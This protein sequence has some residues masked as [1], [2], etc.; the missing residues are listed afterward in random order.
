MVS[1]SSRSGFRSA[2]LAVVTGSFWFCSLLP[3]R[4][5]Q[6]P[7]LTGALP[8]IAVQSNAGA[9]A[10]N[11][12][13]FF[14]AQDAPGTVVRMVFASDAITGGTGSI[15]IALSDSATPGTVANF[16]NYVRGGA[17]V[18]SFLHRSGS[19]EGL[20]IIQGGG[21][22]IAN[23]T[24]DLSASTLTAVSTGS[25]IVNES[26]TSRPNARGT[27][28]MARTSDPN[29]ATSQWFINTSDNTTNLGGSD[30]AGYTVFGTV[31][32]AGMDVADQVFA[33]PT[34]DVHGRI[35]NN[36][37]GA[38]TELPTNPQFTGTGSLTIPR[39]DLVVVNSAGVIPALTFSAQSDTPS[40]A[41]I[42]TINPDGTI[43]LLLGAVSGTA[44]VTV[45]V[46]DLDGLSTSGSFAVFSV[47]T[48]AASP[49]GILRF[50]AQRYDVDAGDNFAI[51]SVTR[52]GGTTGSV[53]AVVS[54]EDDSA[55][56]GSDYTGVTQTVI[57][58]DGD[59]APKTVIIPIHNSGVTTG[60][61]AFN[62][63]LLNP[64]G[65]AI[66]GTNNTSSVV[67]QEHNPPGGTFGF[68]I[69]EIRASGTA[70]KVLVQRFGSTGAAASVYFSTSNGSA[71]DGVHY[72]GVH[73]FLSF[74]AGDVL[75]TVTVP[76]LP[77][78]DTADRTVNLSLSL[79]SANAALGLVPQATVVIAHSAQTQVIA[80]QQPSFQLV[81]GVTSAITLTRTGPTDQSAWALVQFYD[82][83]AA[84][85]IDYISG[86]VSGVALVNFAAGSSTA[87]VPISLASEQT[88]KFF[89]AGLLTVSPG[90][91]I[92][93]LD[94][95]AVDILDGA[96]FY[97]GTFTVSGSCSQAV[98]PVL[99]SATAGT[100]SVG[101][102]TD[103]YT[104]VPGTDYNT[105]AGTL[106]FAPGETLKT[107]TVPILSTTSTVN[108]TL[109]LH[110]T[111]TDVIAGND[112]Q[113]VIT[114]DPAAQY[115]AM[116][117]TNYTVD[118]GHSLSV[119]FTRTGAAL[120][121]A[122]AALIFEDQTAV[123]DT[124]YGVLD[125]QGNLMGRII[126]VTFASGSSTTVV[127]IVTAG[128]TGSKHFGL[129]LLSG[130]GSYAVGPVT[131]ASV[132]ILSSHFLASPATVRTAASGTEAVV[133]VIRT[134]T[135]FAQAVSYTTN[136]GTAVS[137]SDYLA[138]SA[139]L[140]FAAGEASKLIHIP[141]LATSGTA[142][143]SFGVHLVSLA[144]DAVVDNDA[145]VVLVH[146]PA[147]EAVQFDAGSYQLGAGGTISFV[148]T[149]SGATDQA[150]NVTVRIENGAAV[151]GN[152]FAI[153]GATGDLVTV[154]FAAG[155]DTAV[156]TGSLSASASGGG[157]GLRLAST[158]PG[159]EVAG[160]ATATVGV[161]DQFV[162]LPETCSVLESNGGVIVTV[163]RS[164][165]TG[166]G[167]VQFTTADDTAVSGTDYFQ[168]SGTLTFAAGVASQDITVLLKSTNNNSP[169][170]FTVSLFNP[171]G[172][173]VGSNSTATV[174]ILKA[175]PAGVFT[176]GA[177]SYSFDA[178]DFGSST[179][180]QVLRSSTAQA[181]TVYISLIDGSAALDQDYVALDGSNNRL[182]GQRIVELD[183]S[184][185]D[186]AKYLQ[187][188]AS[189]SAPKTFTMRLVDSSSDTAI[190][191]PY[192]ATVN[193]LGSANAGL[194]EFPFNDGSFVY[195]FSETAGNA[196]VPVTRTGTAGTVTVSYNTFTAGFG[197]QAAVD[198]INF[199]GASGTT[200]TF[201]PGET[202]KFISIPLKV[203]PV[204]TA[205][206]C[207][208]GVNLLSANGG[209]VVGANGQAVVWIA[210]NASGGVM[211][212]ANTSYRFD[213]GVYQSITVNRSV[214]NGS[215]YAFVTLLPS[216]PGTPSSFYATSNGRSGNLVEVDFAD[217]QA[218]ATLSLGIASGQG[219]S[220]VNVELTGAS[221][222]AA[223]GNQNR[224]S[225]TFRDVNNFQ[226]DSPTYRYSAAAGSANIRVTRP[227]GSGTVSVAY[228]TT[229]GSAIAGRDYTIS[230]A[231]L[232]FLPGETEHIIS[233]PL[234]QAPGVTAARSFSL[235]L[236][237]P[238]AG[239]GLGPVST[240]T[241]TVV[242]NA[243]I[244]VFSFGQNS[245][246]FDSGSWLQIVIQ[247]AGP[248]AALAGAAT[249]YVELLESTGGWSGS[250]I[251][252][253][254][255]A[256]V[257]G[258]PFAAGQTSGT[259]SIA[260]YNGVGN[261]TVTVRL[262]DASAGSA[263]G[264]P[265]SAT[266]LFVDTARP[267]GV[268]EFSAPTFR[269]DETAGLATVTVTRSNIDDQVTVH[270]A[271]ADGSAK[272]GVDYTASSSDLTFAPGVQT[273]TFSVPL[274]DVPAPAGTRS[275]SVVLSNVTGSAILGEQ[276]VASVDIVDENNSQGDFEFDAA[277]YSFN[278]DAGWAEVTVTRNGASNAA[279][280]LLGTAD[281]AGSL[282]RNVVYGWPA[283]SVAPG[284]DVH[285]EPGQSSQK[286]FI[287]LID[288]ALAPG[289]SATFE[290]FLSLLGN[291]A[292]TLGFQN[293][294][295]VTLVSAPQLAVPGVEFASTEYRVDDSDSSVVLQARLYGA[296]ATPISVPFEVIPS[297]TA[298]FI[299]DFT[300]VNAANVTLQSALTGMLTFPAGATVC[301]L[302]IRIGHSASSVAEKQFIVR[303]DWPVSNA[304]LL[305][306]TAAR[307]T[308]VNRNAT[309]GIFEFENPAYR[310]DDDCGTVRLKIVRK[311]TAAQLAGSAKI[312][313]ETED[314]SAVGRKFDA[315]GNFTGFQ[316]YG[317]NE[318]TFTFGP[319][320]TSK[321][322]CVQVFKN[323]FNS[324]SV[325]FLARIESTDSTAHAGAQDRAVVTLVSPS[326]LGVAGF[327]FDKPYYAVNETDGTV[328][329]SV[330]RVDVT[331]AN[332]TARDTLKVAYSTVNGTARAGVDFTRIAGT[333][334]FR[335]GH[336]VAKLTVHV[337]NRV[338]AQNRMF[339]LRLS[340]PRDLRRPVSFG[341]L[342]NS[343]ATVEI[344][345]DGSPYGVFR[346]SRSSYRVSAKAKVLSLVLVRSG[347]VHSRATVQVRSGNG[348]A[349]SGVDYSGF[350][351]VIKF[352]ANQTGAQLKVPIVNAHA[353]GSR[354]FV[355]QIFP[356]TQGATGAM[357]TATI[358]ITPAR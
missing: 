260:E 173:I 273:V 323:S 115:I 178:Q 199:T 42:G 251:A 13:S 50:S 8:N 191:T 248:S 112:A 185:G 175:P 219:D 34:S 326:R 12:S 107:F 324:P 110:L 321:T 94:T 17:Y 170:R 96:A 250:C 204:T 47:P 84:Y 118:Q 14:Q 285:F 255:G 341:S 131:T 270:C 210:K 183:F 246:R 6:A 151:L 182:S 169:R 29:S 200:I 227:A 142:D 348:T 217:G 241:I 187:I 122:T 106:T 155:S 32:G 342:P 343:P 135:A 314:G 114:N 57:F 213:S 188:S 196:L 214:T 108:R 40:I 276:A 340:N 145:T 91:T 320:E 31:L 302:P 58:A 164:V 259:V 72:T 116:D 139:T 2:I 203:A 25:A 88:R 143:V 23:S 278:Q 99:R 223:V 317:Y 39:A 267:Q 353:A 252:S 129:R 119:T 54:T 288:G 159:Y 211:S 345:G 150:A 244:G 27:I 338:L 256:Q 346:L 24:S 230:S 156:I 63:S 174:S 272:A 335:P 216:D 263:I 311:G 127:S 7:L 33:M 304:L 339:S 93:N 146:D 184:P 258:I 220:M 228:S 45:T 61:R 325:D 283:T 266:A 253:I 355:A 209:A 89:I 125:S 19:P 296:S 148:L 334:T 274:I 293:T 133:T 149:R 101:Y 279:D 177:A 284:L 172:A 316:N 310:F 319:R 166:S 181:A 79:A 113:L 87:S 123:L 280:I 167:S 21:F 20:G 141:I 117:S 221:A 318:E 147:A 254:A 18:N 66:L 190:G 257:V 128:G 350:D 153:D 137:G 201:N 356:T 197:A 26:S 245:Y 59:T 80:F 212:F 234:I 60:T 138:T 186:S 224:T 140:S 265:D 49:N 179:G 100:V 299:A 74:A 30:G 226:F 297:S 262:V 56:T 358:T 124:D 41:N 5:Q 36:L 37:D 86:P 236:S 336:P 295:T 237:N 352:A 282:G 46:T 306:Q 286:V 194:V 144:P 132:E 242:P 240:T 328:T 268:V 233:V 287:P 205:P 218:S 349:A 189:V 77:T 82:V 157:F 158:D 347:N 231:T 291:T 62:L 162:F 102:S 85:G 305:T 67:I 44:N 329:V 249:A 136:D 70:A 206:D 51:V 192:S 83:S 105:A 81:Q 309:R 308:I 55:T 163:K 48:T 76:L 103:P 229:D 332:S 78:G 73:T 275:F 222:G 202:Q 160:G 313:V 10:V 43:R 176:L 298:Q 4:A 111:S 208:F 97:A 1:I 92:Q 357:D 238:S 322:F 351:Q 52:S 207:G 90:Y 35:D 28:S 11:A 292:A 290:V 168:K 333:L 300:P 53:S 277:S 3:S 307:V 130:F 344:R 247:R 98:I 180:L 198:G 134:G 15:D 161:S 71:S 38:F 65:G 75:K 121:S 126:P 195:R 239:A 337:K 104:A 109:W 232:T 269:V 171:A 330:R 354:Y 281:Y 16:L 289:A 243:A 312:M 235:S 165:T 152:D 22:K 261:K 69:P 68:V 225:I 95:A 64:S 193:L 120:D 264:A 315:V 331:G 327:E 154:T 303:L 294:A 9:L 271:T 215:A 301:N